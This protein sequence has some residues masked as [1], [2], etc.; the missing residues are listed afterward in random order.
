MRI[1]KVRNLMY[2]TRS[3]VTETVEQLSY[4]GL[5]NKLVEYSHLKFLIE[6]K[7]IR[8]FLTLKHVIV[9]NQVYLVLQ[10]RIEVYPYSSQL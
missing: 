1:L 4:S 5:M 6:K 7:M 3:L 9:S 8:S 10:D 2:A